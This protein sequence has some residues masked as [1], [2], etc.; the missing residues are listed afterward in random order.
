LLACNPRK[1]SG[2]L[3]LKLFSLDRIERHIPGAIQGDA[4]AQ[5]ALY[6]ALSPYILGLCH[7]Y[8]PQEDEAED[9]MIQ[10]MI[11]FFQKLHTYR[12]DAPVKYWV[13]RMAVNQCLMTLRKHSAIHQP[14]MNEE[15]GLD[16]LN[17]EHDTA[18]LLKLV[19]SL[20]AGFRTV[21][22]L[23]AI[24]GFSHAEIAESLGISEGTSKSQL[25]RARQ[26]LQKA[27]VK[28]ESDQG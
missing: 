16:S 25:S 18:H 8:F 11:T 21:F 9:H 17:Q 7:R 12:G 23:Y 10:T 15:L 3:E 22:N 6:D 24:E 26:W 5:K 27:L 13:R 2:I 1:G 19:Q 14:F 28:T 20:P 4:K